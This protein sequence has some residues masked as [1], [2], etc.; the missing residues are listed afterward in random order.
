MLT[1]KRNF[2][3]LVGVVILIAAMSTTS[4]AN[5][6]TKLKEEAEKIGAARAETELPDMPAE[7][8]RREPYPSVAPGMEARVVARRFKRSLDAANERFVGQCNGRGGWY[9]VLQQKWNAAGR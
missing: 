2:Q 5:L 7:C 4:C 3:P 8:K 9:D 1:M 6:Q